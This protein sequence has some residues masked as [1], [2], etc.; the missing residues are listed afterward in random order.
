[1]ASLLFIHSFGMAS[2]DAFSVIQ[3][4]VKDLYRGL[5]LLESRWDS[6]VQ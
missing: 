3:N 2:S 4:E 6:A 1:M 5:S